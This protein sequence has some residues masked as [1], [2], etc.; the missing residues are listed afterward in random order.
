MFEQFG[1]NMGG[2]RQRRDQEMKTEDVVMP[3]YLSLKQLYLGEVFDVEYSREVLCMNWKECTKKSQ[4]C[5]GPGVKVRTQQLAPGFVQQVQVKD[6]KCIARGKMWRA[7]CR[8][9][10]KGKTE[11]ET[12]SLTVDVNKGMRNGEVITFE[13]VADEKVGYSAGDLVM[14]IKERR[15]EVS[16][17]VANIDCDIAAAFVHLALVVVSCRRVYANFYIPICSHQPRSSFLAMETTCTRQWR[18][19]W[20]ML[21]SALKTH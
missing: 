18:F 17:V 12:T 1:F 7:N 21:S 13:G 10:P 16:F 11:T 14:V 2:G 3:I 20:W 8:D 6:D 4:D 5:Q 19:L 9:C 15:H